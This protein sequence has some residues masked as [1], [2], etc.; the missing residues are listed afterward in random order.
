MKDRLLGEIND[1]ELCDEPAGEAAVLTVECEAAEGDPDERVDAYL[2]RRTG[3]SRS[4]VQKLISAGAVTQNG[5]VVR[6]SCRTHGGDVFVLQ[7]PAPEPSEATAEDIPLDVVYEDGDIIVVNKPQGMVVHP[8][9][10]HASGTLVSALLY[11]CGD[12]LSGIGGVLRPGIVHRID[13]DTAGLICAAKNDGAHLSLAAQLED[14]SMCRTYTAILTG[15]LPEMSGRVEAPIGR[16]PKDR[17]KMAVVSGGR[18]AATNYRVLEEYP[19]F[20]LA[21]M[22][23]ETGRT[24][25]IR[26]HMAY[27]G[28]PVLGDPVYGA[29]TQF[30]RRHPALFRGQCLFAR[31]LS[32]THPSTEERMTFSAPLPENFEE[33]IRLLRGL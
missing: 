26:V 12:S 22:K 4:A 10:G 21:E 16:H 19:G 29:V 13:R 2:A 17:K 5:K 31:E 25:Q 1:A 7:V 20:T 6:G 3:M 8:A 9:P 33:I 14:H 23:L 27:M 32:L 15:H 30:E 28:H 18:P 11:H 24:H